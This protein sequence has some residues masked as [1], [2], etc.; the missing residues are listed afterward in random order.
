MKILHTYKAFLPDVE[1][2]VIRVMAGLTSPAQP[3]VESHILVARTAGFSRRYEH[4][5]NDT[6]AVS[7]LGT[8]MSMPIAPGYVTAF[9][10]ESRQADLVVHHA[11]FPLADL[12][13]ALAMPRNVKLIV[14]WHADIIG[15]PLMHSLLE[16]VIKAVMRRA[17]RIVVSDETMIDN[18]PILSAHRAKCTV[19]PYGVDVDYWQNLT[20]DERKHVEALK[21]EMPRLVVAVGRLVGYKG[22]GNLISA[23]QHVDATVAIVG[24][25]AMA[26]DLRN[27]AKMLGVAERVRFLGRLPRPQIKCLIHAGRMLAMPS[28]SAAEAFGLVQLEAM[29]AGRPVVNT[30]LNTAVPRIARHGLEGL[31]VPPEDVPALAA[32]IKRLLDDP[33]YAESLGRAGQARAKE[34]YQLGRFREENFKLYRGVLGPIADNNRG[35]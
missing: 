23:L 15:R 32:A 14:D 10:R 8:L 20:D 28:V 6:H 12:A 17:D 1:G 29:S 3:G 7:S 33:A 13:I 24:D 11:P 2:G 18:S 4:N 22:F 16:P 5:G 21:L 34:H 26:D 25:G 35:G 27:I 19:I 30:S 9:A 31:T